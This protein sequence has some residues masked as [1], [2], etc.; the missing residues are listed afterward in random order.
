MNIFKSWLK[1][2][3]P[4]EQKLLAHRAGTSR[5][6]LY[7]LSGGFR[8]AAPELAAAI[9]RETA[10]MHKA[11]KGRLPLIYRTDLAKACANCSFAQQCLGAAAVRAEFEMVTP[12]ML[13]DGD[14]GTR[15]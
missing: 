5:A 7:H 14:E 13:D 15:G 3:T 12:E 1:A 9:E 4:D 10:A 6:Y 2:A 11:S 8:S